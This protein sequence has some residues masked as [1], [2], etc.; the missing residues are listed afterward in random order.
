MKILTNK[1]KEVI[2]KS[3]VMNEAIE[4]GQ[5]YWYYSESCKVFDIGY[6]CFEVE[7]AP[8]PL[9]KYCYTLEE[10]FYLNPNWIEP[11]KPP[12]QIV[13]ELEEKLNLLTLQK[14]ESEFEIDGRLS[15]LELGLA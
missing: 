15:K 9:E 1:D 2:F 10:G 13:K 7:S 6:S 8:E 11:P 5:K 4:D 12:E 14:A 3:D